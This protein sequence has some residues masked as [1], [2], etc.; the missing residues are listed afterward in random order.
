MFAE[1]LTVNTLSSIL[2]KLLL[3]GKFLLSIVFGI[4]NDLIN[5]LIVKLLISSALIFAALTVWSLCISSSI[6]L[7][8]FFFRILHQRDCLCLL[9]YRNSLFLLIFLFAITMLVL[10]VFIAVVF[11]FRAAS[12]GRAQGL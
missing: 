10:I 3:H 5:S 1:F 9:E 2:F 12:D 8:S 11:A 4:V 6:F 7:F